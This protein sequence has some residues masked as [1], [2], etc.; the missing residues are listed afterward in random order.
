VKYLK[1]TA[2]RREAINLLAEVSE[3]R[4]EKEERAGVLRQLGCVSGTAGKPA[5]A[6]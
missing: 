2:D 4:T 5:S 1:K 3:G 6:V